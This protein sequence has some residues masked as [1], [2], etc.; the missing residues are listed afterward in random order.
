MLV[1]RPSAEHRRRSVSLSAICITLI[2]S[3]KSRIPVSPFAWSSNPQS[4]SAATAADHQYAGPLVCSSD[5]WRRVESEGQLVRG[6]SWSVS[7]PGSSS[8]SST[9]S[10]E[11]GDQ[12]EAVN[13]ARMESVDWLTA[14]TGRFL[15][16]AAHRRS[17]NGIDIIDQARVR[18]E[19]ID[20]VKYLL[21]ALPPN[22]TQTEL[23]KLDSALPAELQEIAEQRQARRNELRRRRKSNLLSKTISWTILRAAMLL[24]IF[25]P[26]LLGLLGFCLRYERDNRL[27]E[28]FVD[29]ATSGLNTLQKREPELQA[30]VSRFGHGRVGKA[31]IGGTAWFIGGVVQGVADGAGRSAPVLGSAIVLRPRRQ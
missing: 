6:R 25:L 23:D 26:L 27:T 22:M 11:R 16:D 3:W 24:S 19:Y 31:L 10:M 12:G 5:A 18:E 17:A 29:L 8:T 2:R 30:C 20:G 14:N 4:S 21:K 9:V 15:C 13:S 28:K 7:R 1:T